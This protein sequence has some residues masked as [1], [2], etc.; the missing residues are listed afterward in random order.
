MIKRSIVG[1]LWVASI[2]LVVITVTILGF[3][4]SQW[5]EEFYFNQRV[6][7]LLEDG[8]MLARFVIQE[9][10]QQQVWEQ[11]DLLER[12]LGASVM[13]LD[14]NGLIKAHGGMMGMM[15][16]GPM[17]HQGVNLQGQ[18]VDRV[19]RGETVILRGNHPGFSV[20]VVTVAIPVQE[21][22]KVQGA[23]L[24]YAP[25]API[26]QTLVAIRRLFGYGALIA[27]LAATVISFFLSRRISRPLL[28]MHQVAAG[29][30]RGEFHQRVQPAGAD[31]VGRLGRSLNHLAEVLQRNLSDLS[32]EKEQRDNILQSM[33]DGVITV[34]RQGLVALFNPPAARLLQIPLVTG[35]CLPAGKVGQELAVLMDQSLGG[36]RITGELVLGDQML[37]V[38]AAPLSQEGGVVALIQDMT[39]E[40]RLEQLRRS[41]V[42]AVSHELRTPLTL[43]QGYTEAIRDGLA[44]T[45]TEREQYLGIILDESH[46]LRRLVD[47]LLDLTQIQAGT[48]RLQLQTINL[49]ELVQ[50]AVAKWIPKAD[51][52]GLRLQVEITAPLPPV[53]V[54]PDRMEQVL[55]NLLDNAFRH[56]Q[57]GEQIQV[58]VEPVIG[59]VRVAI[60]DTGPGIDLTEQ[61]Y[62]WERFYKAD[63]ARTRGQQ[64]TG[65]GLAIAREI[66]TA[67]GGSIGV[68][69]SRGQGSV[70][71]LV[72]PS[73]QEE[74][75][76][77]SG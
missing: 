25:V 71:Y 52:Q 39:I 29:M 40:Y 47:D 20:P 11:I 55:Q 37:R 21:Q 22:D 35:Q 15:G 38:A 16:M 7:E 56:S 76:G 26:T 62:I 31:E 34:D 4:L 13:V 8:N 57:A 19:L 48:I 58:D 67:H 74:Q 73:A 2:L 33:T 32:R 24:L 14:R 49:G 43:I 59:G 65:L 27:I 36:E 30:A 66:V 1:K 5:L 69:S 70:F 50:G 3:L 42:G 18:E 45:T 17:M 6:A 51:Q 68:E 64:G 41:F 28:Q 10:G 75:S 63:R 54:D 12:F 72:I 23:V 46:R 53:S 44:A 77:T 60:A 61:P 9:P